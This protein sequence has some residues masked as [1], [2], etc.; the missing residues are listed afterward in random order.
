MVVVNLKI[1]LLAQLV[2]AICP[3]RISHSATIEYVERSFLVKGPFYPSKRFKVTDMRSEL[4]ASPDQKQDERHEY[5]KI[6]AKCQF[7]YSRM[8]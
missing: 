8:T 7:F 2:T 5:C 4:N 1:I 3:F 6:I